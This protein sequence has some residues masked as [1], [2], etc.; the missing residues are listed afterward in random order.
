L[1]ALSEQARA[2][3][4]VAR[5]LDD[6]RKQ[7]ILT[8]RA[9]SEHA[10]RT[11]E[12]DKAIVD[13]TGSLT[14]LA[15]SIKEQKETAARVAQYGEEARRAASLLPQRLGV[16]AKT[17]AELA[18]RLA[19]TVSGAEGGNGEAAVEELANAVQDVRIHVREIGG[20]TARRNRRL[21]SVVS[22]V[23][24]LA[25]QAAEVR[26]AGSDAAADLS[27]LDEAKAEGGAPEAGDVA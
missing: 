4:E 27:A 15:Q 18:A 13:I 20:A 10:K 24:E 7:S 3:T 21:A 9:W 16:H 22:S 25:N 23:R 17:G 11:S 26:R 19:A 2:A 12:F 5:T 8:A 14:S 6:I 1:T